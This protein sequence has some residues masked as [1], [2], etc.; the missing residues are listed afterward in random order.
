MAS[1][2]FGQTINDGEGKEEKKTCARRKMKGLRKETGGGPGLD[3]TFYI[4]P[5]NK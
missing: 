2:K 4:S 1:F 3:D 5:F